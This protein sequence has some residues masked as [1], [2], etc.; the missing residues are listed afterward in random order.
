M[1]LENIMLSEISQTKR[2]NIVLLQLYKAP[3]KKQI[4]R[5]RKYNR[6]Y[7]GMWGR[8]SKELFYKVQF[9]LGRMKKF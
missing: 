9:L 1:N 8:G 6:Y 5:D 3:K 7:E 2:T 4:C